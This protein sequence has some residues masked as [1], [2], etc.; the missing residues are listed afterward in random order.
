MILYSLYL[1]LVFWF[2]GY[3][4]HSLTD[5]LLVA[6][7]PAFIGL[8]SIPIPALLLA[9]WYQTPDQLSRVHI[10][11]LCIM[12]QTLMLKLNNFQ[13]IFVLII[14]QSKSRLESSLSC[15]PVLSE[16]KNMGT[17]PIKKSLC[18]LANKYLTLTPPILMLRDFAPLQE[19]L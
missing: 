8:G 6:S 15:C 12:H 17:I 18:K 1:L 19:M 2:P 3:H 5:S 14:N 10:L 4:C 16:L 11:S 7:S 13:N 9:G